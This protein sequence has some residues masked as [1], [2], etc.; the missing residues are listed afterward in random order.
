MKKKYSDTKNFV[1][2]RY[3]SVIF[4]L[5]T[6]LNLIKQ[7]EDEIE[8]LDGQIFNYASEKY[9]SEMEILSRLWLLRKMGDNCY[10]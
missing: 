1:Q 5:Q 2:E 10:C 6:H 9:E 8:T 4:R 7:R 3:H